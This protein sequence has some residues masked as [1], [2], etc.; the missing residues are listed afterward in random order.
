MY[1]LIHI[2][3]CMLVFLWYYVAC[4]P[5]VVWNKERMHPCVCSNSC[6]SRT[7]VYVPVLSIAINTAHN[8][9]EDSPNS[10]VFTSICLYITVRDNC[11]NYLWYKLYTVVDLWYASLSLAA[12]CTSIRASFNPRK[13]RKCLQHTRFWICCILFRICL[14]FLICCLNVLLR[15]AK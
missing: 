1:A 9:L 12:S 2:L 3:I 10:T 14:A 11:N 7:R 15:L 8:L 13:K 4:F 5:V 6:N